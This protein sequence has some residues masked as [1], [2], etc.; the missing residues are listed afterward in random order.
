M[1]ETARE[2]LLNV[3]KHS[4]TLAARME[5]RRPDPD[6]LQLVVSDAGQGCDPARIFSPP[7]EAD[8]G[9]HFGLFSVRERSRLLGGRLE[10][11]AAPGRG[12]RFQLTV[13]APVAAATAPD[14]P[15]SR[16]SGP[17]VTGIVARSEEVRPGD[18]PIRTLLVDDHSV[19]REGLVAMLED[20]VDI[21]VVGE[22]AD[23]EQ[24]LV[25]ARR[26]RPDI[27]LMDFSMPGMDG[28]AATRAIR[29]E[30]PETRVIGL[31]MYPE[32]D[33]GAAMLGPGRRPTCRR[34]TARPA[35]WRPSGPRP[36]RASP[37]PTRTAAPVAG[38][39][40]PVGVVPDRVTADPSPRCPAAP[41]RR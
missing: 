3:A 26:L 6:H 32:S 23:G 1:F 25:L 15:P 8:I 16:G 41:P 39:R 9:S 38:G 30:M 17:A 24:A 33:R 21:D 22:A 18:H 40:R 37:A 34:A 29:D 19:M 13:P 10:V 36:A 14:V 5:L 27:V 4:G 20:E 7:A 2:L 31:S 11:A 35:C 12:A 28:V